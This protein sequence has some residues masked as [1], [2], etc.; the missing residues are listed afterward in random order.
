[1]DHYGLPVSEQMAMLHDLAVQEHQAGLGI[2]DRTID[3]N[4]QSAQNDTQ[5]A[6]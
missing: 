4:L 2:V 1:M 6:A 5:Q 3:A